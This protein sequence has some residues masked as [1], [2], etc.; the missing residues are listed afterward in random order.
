MKFIEWLSIWIDNYVRPNTKE[1]TYIRYRQL[2]NNHIAATLGELDMDELCP[3]TL[4]SFV[5]EKLYKGNIK[6]GEKLSASFVNMLISIIQ[7]SL[8][9]AH[10]V[11]AVKEYVG[12]K[13]KRPPKIEKQVMCFS[14]QEQKKIENYI[15]SSAKDKLFGIILCLY[16]GLRIGEL[17]ALRWEDI[18]F[19][20]GLVFVS[21]TCRD[22]T[23][24]EK[25][26][27]VID[28]PKTVS[29]QRVIPLPKVILSF[30]KKIKKFSKCDYLIADGVKPVFVRSYQRTFELVLKK[31]KM[32]HKGF[33]ALRHTFATRAIECGMDVKTLSE[34]LGHKNASTTLSRYTHSLL[35]HKIIMMNR[36]GKML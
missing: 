3:I 36:L 9:T 2:I 22:A 14:L 20:N 24:N 15:F 35:Q 18:D 13:I 8:R 31:L 33:H 25:H 6:T 32:E 16:T 19:S 30:L 21:K 4:Q 7:N 34:I 29:S 28:V 10:M 12:G 26:I 11:N 17:L 23:K 1:S 5:T 27:R